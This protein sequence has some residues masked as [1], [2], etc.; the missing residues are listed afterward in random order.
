MITRIG[1]WGTGAG[2]A[3]CLWLTVGSASA[4][5]KPPPGKDAPRVEAH[6][7]ETHNMDADFAACLVLDNQNEISAARL[8]EERTETS[9]VKKFA[10]M[11]QDDHSKFIA[12][13]EKFGGQQFQARLKDK[14]DSRSEDR[15]SDIEARDNQKKEAYGKTGTKREGVAE[16]HSNAHLQIRHE[17]A[18]ECLAS[19]RRELSD[20][21]GLEFDACYLGM[22]IAAHMRMVDELKV[23]ERHATREMQPVLQAGRK[24]AEG[25][26]QK[27]KDLMKELEKDHEARTAQRSDSK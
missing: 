19:T 24:T 27:A 2:L 3:A 25:H 6:K 16:G 21:K 12:E 1:K 26:L 7:A 17:I 9:Q 13:L 18:D 20:K 22:Q 14:A 15:R 11:L 5:Q 4:Q 8:A 10:R 23:L